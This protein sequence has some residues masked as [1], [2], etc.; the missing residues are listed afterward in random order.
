M[1]LHDKPPH[2]VTPMV[3][4]YQ[5]VARIITVAFEMVTPGVLGLWLD[6]WL[7]TKVLFT[8][9]GFAVGI[10]FAVWHLIRMTAS[11]KPP[12]SKPRADS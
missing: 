11:P 3:I 7:G 6:N 1:V 8:L 2:D 10:T 5:W 9:L 12:Q 4:A